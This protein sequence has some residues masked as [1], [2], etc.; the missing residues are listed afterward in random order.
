MFDVK[1]ITIKVAKNGWI[2]SCDG[3][4]GVKEYE[5]FE[6]DFDDNLDLSPDRQAY[7]LPAICDMLASIGH[8]LLQLDPESKETITVSVSER[9]GPENA[10]LEPSDPK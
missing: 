4:E 7:K 3:E 2:L 1:E 6:H 8:Y 10:I 5:L 9:Q